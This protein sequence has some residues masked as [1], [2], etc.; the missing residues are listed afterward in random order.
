M[1]HGDTISCGCIQKEIIS[2]KFAKDL[3]GKMFGAVKVIKP[4]G[5]DNKHG[6][7]IWQC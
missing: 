6:D 4:D 5:K 2:K 1:T 7:I 3:T